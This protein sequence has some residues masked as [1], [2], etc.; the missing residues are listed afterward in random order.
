M[1][2]PNILVICSDQHHTRMSGYRDF[3]VQTPHL[4]ALAERGTHFTRAYCNSP[5]CVPSRMSFITGKYVHQIDSWHI[6]VPL[7]PEEMTWSRRLHNAGIESTLLGKLDMCGEYQDAGFTHH[8]ILRR[9]RAFPQIPLKE[10]FA[11]RLKGYVRPD[12]RKW[13]ENACTRPPELMSDGSGGENSVLIGNYDHDRIVTNWALDYLR[14]KGKNK[15]TQPWALYVGHLFPHWP[16][17][18][19]EAYYNLYNPAT[20]DLPIDASFPNENL[21]P[22]LRHFQSAL[23]IDGLSEENV[24]KVIATYYGMISCMDAMVGE[25][26]T[27]LQTQGFADNTVII[28]TSDHGESLGEHGLFYKQCAYEGSVG[29][30]LIVSGP[31]LPQGQQIDH[32]VSLVDMYPTLMDIAGLDT[33]PDHPGH[34]W[35]PTIHGDHKPDYAFSE[36]HG[37]FLRHAWYMLVREQYKYIYYDNERP[38]LFNIQEDPQECNDLATDPEYQSVLTDFETQL[39]TICDPET[40]AHRAKHDLG[41]IGPNGEDYTQTLHVDDLG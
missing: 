32:P 38:S 4:D 5:V 7:D 26:L 19:P 34:S 6:G 29:I 28:Y 1:S 3:P 25:I 22:A 24:R 36:Y 17:S 9:R 15:S 40:T 33:E 27:E 8:K 12:K 14:E 41:L 23:G 2:K 20:V 18:V 30:P 39:H 10:P 13:V 35:L 16:F 11:A 31:D 37:N 21:H